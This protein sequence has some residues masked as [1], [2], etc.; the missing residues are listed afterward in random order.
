MIESNFFE[1]YIGKPLQSL[2]NFLKK[3]RSLLWRLLGVYL[4]FLIFS[5]LALKIWNA[6]AG[7]S[8]PWDIPI[9]M[10]I[11]QTAQP[12]L[13]TFAS[14]LTQLGGFHGAFPIFGATALVLIYQKKWRKFVYLATTGLG[15]AIINQ[16]VKVLMHRERPHLWESTYHHYGYAFPSGHSMTSMTLILVIIILTWKTSWRLPATILGSLFVLAIAWTRL[17]LGVHYPSDI[18]AGWMVAIAWVIGVTLTIKPNLIPGHNQ[19]LAFTEKIEE[20]GN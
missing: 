2:T 4:P 9:L 10:A 7:F 19:N 17:Y 5:I 6:Q 11:H 13:D 14:T 12:Q 15:N 1:S 20:S 18:L 16:T 8:F 3:T